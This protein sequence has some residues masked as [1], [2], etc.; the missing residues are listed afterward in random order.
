MK[1]MDTLQHNHSYCVIL[2]GGQGTR[3]WP[4]SREAKPKQ[5]LDFFGM[6]RTLLQMTYDRMKQVCS[7]DHIFVLTQENYVPLVK[8]QLPDIP[9]AH[10]LHEPIRRNTAPSTMLATLHLFYHDPEANLVVVPSDQLIMRDEIF[11]KEVHEGLE[12]VQQEHE[13]LTLAI[14]PTRPDTN[15]GYIQISDEI[16][17]NMYKMKSFV[18]KPE[19]EFARFFMQ[20]G[21]FYWNTAIFVWRAK[22]FIEHARK[23]FPDW[24][25]RMEMTEWN[26]E[27]LKQIQANYGKTLNLSLDSAIFEVYAQVYVKPCTFGW[28]DMGNWQAFYEA[29][30]KDSLENVVPESNAMCYNSKGN[31]FQVPQGKYVVAEDLNGYV[32]ID[33]SDLLVI[34]PRKNAP[35]W[36][37][38][39]NDVQINL[40]DKWI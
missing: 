22:D 20:T 5:F 10:I 34:C 24:I 30:P 17:G 23:L 7:A 32:V 27:D 6:G 25:N 3:F 39:V 11:V 29:S 21:E 8:E 18:E 2:A 15:Y 35:K 37:K 4:V 1:P 38:Y 28:A 16:K 31:I 12:F 13:L 9:D 33:Q 36:K 40:G 26:E 19:E 14:K